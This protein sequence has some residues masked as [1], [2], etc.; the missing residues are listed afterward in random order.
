MATIMTGT[1][2]VGTATTTETLYRD[3]SEGPGL[4]GAFGVEHSG[5]R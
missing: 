2:A 1:T 3:G 5:L 4:A